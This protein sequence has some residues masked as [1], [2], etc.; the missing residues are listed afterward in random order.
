M[1][2]QPPDGRT[3]AGAATAA[4]LAGLLL[5]TAPVGAQSTAEVAAS[6]KVTV[7]RT[8]D[9]P[10][11][12]G[13]PVTITATVLVPTFMPKPP[14]WPDLEVAD[15]ITRLPERATHPVTQ[16]V[17]RESWSG[18]ARSWEIIPQRPADFDF[19]PATI[20]ITYA[21]PDS[22]APVMAELPLPPVTLTAT[23]PPGAEGLDPFLTASALTL[24]ATIEGLPAS[25]K[26]GD[27]FTLTLAATAS[28]PPAMLLPPLA[29]RLPDL[30]GLRAYPRT[31]VLADG[32]PATRTEAVTYVIEAPGHYALPGLSVGW[33]NVATSALE[34]A[35]TEA[36]IV[37]VPAPPGWRSADA[38]RQPPR[39]LLVAA[40]ALVLA[41]AVAA[42]R[43]LPPRPPS[44]RS[45]YRALRRAIR[46]SP[47][48]AIRQALASWIEAAGIPP[49]PTEPALRQLERARY[50]PPS[51]SE[52]TLPRLDL[53]RTV[54]SARR[55][56]PSPRISRPA[57]LPS[58]NADTS[59]P[60]HQLHC[61]TGM[62][63][64]APT[65]KS[66]RS[67]SG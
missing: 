6:P 22:S 4:L 64:S 36:V 28:G 34:T 57:A 67:A 50:G 63:R 48:D 25:P 47:P 20:T 11:T 38:A 15:A 24:T 42:A 52:E 13:T 43:W 7:T 29:S 54:A 44:E 59:C 31:P 49:P 56:A 61:P 3:R 8:P 18:L 9:G 14:V 53:M 45:L 35:T 30:P 32:D 65:L 60:S 23:V 46:S 19:G 2:A 16:R 41:A 21:D 55:A 5:A 27:A 10:V 1:I 26:P 40:A 17:G 37:D 51:Q 66:W 62:R 33:W 58:L 12:V 39:G